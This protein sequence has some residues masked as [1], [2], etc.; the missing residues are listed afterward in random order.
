[1]NMH[2]QMLP[3][4]V[5]L[6]ADDA[7]WIETRAVDQLLATARTPGCCAAVGM[8]DLHPGRGVPIGA[9]FAFRDRVLPSLV[10][11]DAGC[12]VR[13]IGLARCKRRGDAL[14]RRVR[15][16][17]EGP[18]LEGVG[19][20]ALFDA[21][22]RLGPRGLA[23][24]P[25]PEELARIA[26]ACPERPEGRAFAVDPIHHAQQLGT[27]GGGNH[28]LELSRV[29][30]A[31]FDPAT[32]KPQVSTRA[33]SRV[34]GLV[35]KPRARFAILAHSG[36]RA[37]GAALAERWRGRSLET[38]GERARYLYELQGALNYARTNRLLICWRMLRALGATSR[39]R[40][41]AHLDLVHNA[42]SEVSLDGPAWLH[43]K[44]AAPAEA[45]ARTVVLGSRGAPS[46]LM[47]GL[48]SEAA[49]WSVAHGAGRR[50]HRSE[51]IAKLKPRFKRSELQ[52]TRAGSRVL[53]DD[54]ELLYAEHPAAY[55][56]IEPVIESLVHGGAARP[57]WRLHPIL[58]VKR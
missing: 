48:G 22:C 52:R 12:G 57:L 50:M 10:G 27:I 4:H 21:A 23:E 13:L 55:K 5:R 35:G 17:T 28:F 3:P 46:Y 43:R 44:G 41:V 39:Q 7:V 42:V 16:A 51:A 18:A 29:E 38:S 47:E 14:L 24:L 26:A 1:M 49:L 45:G 15:N 40:H 30:I 58:T 33:R 37:L 8:P 54:A 2:H 9:V 36:S 20:M 6:L 34:E 19:G 25:V 53:C 31:D 56:S 32:S 11:S